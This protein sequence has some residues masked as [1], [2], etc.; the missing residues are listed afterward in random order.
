MPLHNVSPFNIGCVRTATA[1]LLAVGLVATTL[2]V[3]AFGFSTS[4]GGHIQGHAVASTTAHGIVSMQLDKASPA[5]G[6]ISTSPRR[7]A[8]PT[9]GLLATC[10]GTHLPE[11]VI[12]LG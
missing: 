1:R 2:S 5:I 11:V 3:A 8:R 6:G 4:P 9:A 12:E 7:T 10:K